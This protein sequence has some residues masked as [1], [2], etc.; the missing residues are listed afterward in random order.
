VLSASVL[1]PA[2]AGQVRR[3]TCAAA[4]RGRPSAPRDLLEARDL[5]PVAADDERQTDERTA[6]PLLDDERLVG[7]QLGDQLAEI[8][9]VVDQP[10]DAERAARAR[11][12]D[13]AGERDLLA[14]ELDRRRLEQRLRHR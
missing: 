2:A 13:R 7:R 5:V 11:G 3:A 10:R 6:R 12:L 9:G 4:G 14:G 1:P 8:G